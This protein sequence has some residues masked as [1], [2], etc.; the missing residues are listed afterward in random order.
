MTQTVSIKQTRDNLADL[1]N[2]VD[3]ANR[4]F[5]ITKFGKP[6][7]MLMPVKPSKRK[8]KAGIAQSFGAWQER[9]DIKKNDTWTREL[10]KKMSMRY[11]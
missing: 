1:I 8:K 5:V 2:Q 9:S 7:A 6:K 3:I 4:E 11:E 10:R